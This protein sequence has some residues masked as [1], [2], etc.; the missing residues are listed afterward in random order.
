MRR[1]CI[2]M[3]SRIMRRRILRRSCASVVGVVGCASVGG[4]ADDDAAADEADADADDD[5]DDDGINV[6]CR[7][8]MVKD[9]HLSFACGTGQATMS[10]EWWLDVTR[11]SIPWNR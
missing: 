5:D 11:W 8:L 1:L 6:I 9:G 7:C 3:S 10:L 2:T 4:D